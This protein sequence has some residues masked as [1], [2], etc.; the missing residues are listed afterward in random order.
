M[1]VSKGTFRRL[2][3]YISAILLGQH[4]R[5]AEIAPARRSDQ[6][7]VAAASKEGELAMKGMQLPAGY[8]VELF[9]AATLG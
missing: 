1:S 4:A 8:K 9:A 2:P 3:I 6:P 5:A 7:K